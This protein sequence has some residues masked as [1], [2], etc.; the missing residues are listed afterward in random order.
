[1]AQV[2]RVCK[3]G[4]LYTLVEE[5]KTHTSLEYS[6]SRVSDAPLQNY[7]MIQQVYIRLENYKHFSTQRYSHKR[8][9]QPDP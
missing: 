5:V 4:T 9:K 7:Y 6:L 2:C 1:M 3:Q 8:S